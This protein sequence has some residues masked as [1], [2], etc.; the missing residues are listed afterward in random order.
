MEVGANELESL[1]FAS[2]SIL[3]VR[4]IYAWTIWHHA[5]VSVELGITLIVA[6]LIMLAISILANWLPRPGGVANWHVLVTLAI[7]CPIAAITGWYIQN[8]KSENDTIT[9][10]APEVQ[11][12]HSRD[13]LP[14]GSTRVRS[15]PN[16]IGFNLEYSAKSFSWK[17]KWA[18][19][20]VAPSVP[21]YWQLA[22]RVKITRAKLPQ[23]GFGLGVGKVVVDEPHAT[24]I[25]YDLGWGGYRAVTYPG[26]E[27]LGRLE[28]GLDRDWHDY[29]LRFDG[30]QLALSVDGS[31]KIE[32]NV[33]SSCAKP[34]LRLWNADIQLDEIELRRIP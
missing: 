8:S 33:S 28:T 7:L 18:G 2:G 34:I 5:E 23:A 22:A 27:T 15:T 11:A 6:S 16:G 12:L 14:F 30:E 25:Q 32:V 13:W 3:D 1:R 17:T 4:L 24:A 21:C 20:V 31:K 26:D 9:D 19:V 29:L 10:Q